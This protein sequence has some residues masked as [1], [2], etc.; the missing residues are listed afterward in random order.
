MTKTQMKAGIF[1]C[2]RLYDT[3][4]W[5]T[6]QSK[7]P[8]PSRMQWI[9]GVYNT[10]ITWLKQ[11]PATFPN[12]TLHDEDHVLNVMFAIAGILGNKITLLSM[13]ECELLI[14]ASAF[15][16]IGMVYDAQGK[17]KAVE[18]PKKCREFLLKNAPDYIGSAF[19]EWPEN[20]QQD[21][22]RTLHPYR[23]PE[24]FADKQWDF[25]NRPREIVHPNIL[26]AVCQSHGEDETF[27]KSNKNLAFQTTNDVDP[28]FCALLLRLGDI[29]DF[30]GTRAPEILFSFAEGKPRSEEAFRKHLASNGFVYPE[31]PSDRELPYSAEC[32][33]PWVEHKIRDYLNWVDYEFAVCNDL[34]K[35]CNKDWQ[36]LF[37][38][39][40]SVSRDQINRIGYDSD[41]FSLTMDQEQILTLLTGK[42]L[43]SSN[44]IFVRELLQ[45]A[46][47][48][49]LLRKQ[50]DPFFDLASDD[51]AIYLWEGLDQNGDLIFRID[52]QG[53]GMTRGMLRRYFLKVGNSYYNSTEIKRDLRK[54]S[55]NTSYYAN[56]RFGIGF[57]SCFLCATQA[58]I[59]TLYFDDYKSQ[60]DYEPGAMN[61]SGFGLRMDISGLRGYYTLRNQALDHIVDI[62]LPYP[63]E[64]EDT[65]PTSFENG[66]YR[67]K[68]G[69]SIVVKLDPG[70][71]GNCNIRNSVQ[72][73]IC[74]TQMPVY[75]NGERLGRTYSEI[76]EEARSLE[77]EHSYELT[78]E[79]KQK[80]DRT[81]PGIKGNYP[82]ILVTTTVLDEPNYQMLPGLS[83]VVTKYKVFYKSPP[84]WTIMDQ[85][86]TVNIRFTFDYEGNKKLLV[87]SC[88]NIKE[89]S[90]FYINSWEHLER[91][92]GSKAIDALSEKF[93]QYSSCPTD[94]AALGEAWNPFA[95]KLDITDVWRSFV[96]KDQKKDMIATFDL[97]SVPLLYRITKN[98]KCRNGTCAYQ[99][100]ICGKVDENY[101]GSEYDAL[102]YL[103]GDLRPSVDVG[104]TQITHLSTEAILAICGIMTSLECRDF[105]IRSE[106]SSPDE[107]LP[108]WREIRLSK[109][110]EW[111]VKTL[112]PRGNNLLAELEKP[113]CKGSRFSISNRY[114]S[115]VAAI[116]CFF[117]ALIQDR[118]QITISYEKGQTLVL[119]R[120]ASEDF[121]EA[122]DPFPPMMFCNAASDESRKFL[123]CSEHACRRGI[124]VDHPFSKW[125]IK[126]AVVLN[127][128]FPHQFGQINDCLRNGNADE[129]IR[130]INGISGQLSQLS[131][132]HGIN[133]SSLPSLAKTDFWE[134][135][136]KSS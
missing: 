42:N 106:I 82:Q 39:P 89:T 125:L 41:D 23:L 88:E 49:T 36:R 37:S 63:R 134:P 80:H 16:D 11:I 4:L 18:N 95:E 50:M 118:Y 14:L 7:K 103:E 110:G 119:T 107:L 84:K 25:S 117:M 124:T 43:Y 93:K 97:D 132:V 21:Y 40:R 92:Y 99:A 78:N 98:N 136:I 65:L 62:P 5:K 30:D 61:S 28:R 114:H 104:R 91:T 81:F 6:Y 94:C 26:V 47:D 10:A 56:S 22:L 31:E 75:Y 27:L 83:G 19:E 87:L 58:E 54:H 130:V 102:F 67:Y 86:Y 105:H 64:F 38:F 71:L 55:C 116:Y 34:K 69:T 70:K 120:K 112:E 15:H 17:K 8:S 53:T 72:D 85:V 131:K 101:G 76:I 96:D 57:L 51:A 135:P 133:I 129:I 1:M 111:L 60:E 108:K 3:A 109:L 48:A 45:N 122:Y 2:L 90:N 59:S 24:L 9:E 29:L 12:Y 128:Y 44:D 74:G 127:K 46:I 20:K 13:G 115:D 100:V 33:E 77:G 68:P 126:N 79:E 32:S 66:G 113:L 123:C 35:L 121:D 73:F 52:D